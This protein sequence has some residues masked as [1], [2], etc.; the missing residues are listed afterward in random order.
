MQIDGHF[1]TLRREMG[2]QA[3]EIRQKM[4]EL[5]DRTQI[6]EHGVKKMGQRIAQMPKKDLVTPNAEHERFL[7]RLAAR[8]DATEIAIRACIGE[9]RRLHESV[10]S[11]LEGRV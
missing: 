5:G 6:L 11:R 4:R 9:C 7:Q 2:Q 1:A 3:L 8:Q 10:V